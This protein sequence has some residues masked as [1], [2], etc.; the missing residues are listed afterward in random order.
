VIRNIISFCVYKPWLTLLFGALVAIAGIQAFKGL[1]IDAVPDITNIQVQVNSAVGNLPPEEIE[2]AVT[3]PVE[4]S[5]NG[6]PG[7]EQVRSITRYGLSQVTVV[8]KDGTDIYRA[9]QLITERLATLQSALPQGVEPSLSPIT[10]GLGEIYHYIVEADKPAEGEARTAQLRELR[11]MQTW[12]VRPRLLT[13]PGVADVNVIGGYEKTIIVSP[14]TDQMKNYGLHFSDLSEALQKVNR[15]VGGSVVEQ[16]GEQFLAVGKGLFKDLNDIKKVPV[17]VLE[18]LKVL[19]INDVA[20]VSE[21]EMPRSGAAVY[22]GR[23]VVLGTVLMLSGANSRTVALDVGKK[24]KEISASLPKGYK[25][26]TM[27]DRSDLVDATLGT[28]KENVM[29]GAVLV[30]IVLLALI[31]N[32][33]AAFI[34]AIVIPLSLLFTFIFMRV[35]DISGNLM[36]L[37]A[38]DFGVITDGAVIVLDNCLR[39]VNEKTKSGEEYNIKE[40]IV[41]AALEIRKSAGFGELIVAMSFIPIFSFVGVEG[42]MFVPMAATFIIAILGSI[43]FSFS[44]VPSMASLLLRKGDKDSEPVVM[45]F[46]QRLYTPTL[47]LFLKRSKVVIVVICVFLGGGIYIAKNLGGEFLPKLDEGSIA[48]QF[49]RPVS[50]GVESSVD[51]DKISHSVV[52]EV[53]EIHSIFGRL[54]T[55][56]I[57]LDP[58]GPNISDTYVMLKPHDEWPKVNGRTR[59]KEEI[60]AAIVEKLQKE[61]PG[62]RVLASQPIQLRFNELLEGTRADVSVKVFGEDQAEITEVAEAVAASIREIPGAGDVEAESKGMQPILE[63]LPK[64]AVTSRLGISDQEVLESVEAGLGGIEVGVFYEGPKRFPLVV[65]LPSEQRT[66]LADIN[67]IPVGILGNQTLP[68]SQIADVRFKDSY[69]SFSREQTKRRVAVLINPRG[70]DTESFVAEAQEKIA[71]EVKIPQGVYLEW[72]GNFKNLQQAKERLFIMGPIALLAILLMVYA[73]FRKVWQTALVFLSVPFALSGS[74]FAMKIAELPFTMSAGVGLIAL[75]GISILN[76]VVLVNFFNELREKGLSG[77]DVILKGAALRVRPVLMTAMTDVL[78]FLPM[79]LSDSPGAE[80]QRPVGLVI[81]SG[82]LCSTVL[83]LLVLPCVY[84]V[85]EKFLNRKGALA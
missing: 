7:V 84:F 66:D 83:T 41:D 40:T 39:L 56:E 21:G 47:D 11:T 37:G 70:T 25:L 23:E 12:T 15:N 14:K 54:G 76:G 6:V 35:F 45:K 10:T 68:L 17:K 69:A 19:T 72:G 22:N 38:L 3:I 33:R 32:V 49:I 77:R 57:A 42:K 52:L 44:V 71:K 5:L 63:I 62:Q 13:V 50:T 58:M 59:T 73:A 74:I 55:A 65:R 78:G 8:F 85:I 24:I 1:P 26:V 18:N 60:V 82:V 81:V 4:M 28:I 75:S 30:M 53:P 51:L 9:R 16:T 61:V 31:G 67:N 36:S 64:Q 20:N 34:S 46:I 2:R 43:I 29:V 80:V 27:Y 79:V 48:L